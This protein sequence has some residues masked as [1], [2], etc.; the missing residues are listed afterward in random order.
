MS[1]QQ[2]LQ[3]DLALGRHEAGHGL[4][5]YLCGHRVER[6]VVGSP[7]GYCDILQPVTPE[8][9]ALKWSQSPLIASL[10]LCR[11]LG[12]LRAGSLCVYR[13]LSGRDASQLAEWQRVYTSHIGT[14]ADWTRLYAHVFERLTAWHRHQSV[15]SAV[16]A[17]GEMLLRQRET[18]RSAFL[19]MVEVCLVDALVPEPVYSP[20][21]PAATRQ[22]PSQASP[23]PLSALVELRDAPLWEDE[24]FCYYAV[25]SLGTSTMYRRENKSTRSVSFMVIRGY[26]NDLE[27][28]P[29]VR[30][31]E[32]ATEAA[33]R[34]AMSSLAG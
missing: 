1:F 28:R 17:I 18:S 11:V 6:I 20:V 7:E 30:G 29:Q 33:A 26:G 34:R 24:T 5:A 31:S 9:L 10:E 8:N 2:D 3:D 19:S 14:N 25:D 32:H 12:T 13:D 16:A 15:R 23:R 22:S 27:G 4:H 21:F